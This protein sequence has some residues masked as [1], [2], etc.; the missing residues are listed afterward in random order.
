MSSVQIIDKKKR[1]PIKSADGKEVLGEIAFNPYDRRAFEKFIDMYNILMNGEK[2]ARKIE[3]DP[4]DFEEEWET[5]EELEK[6]STSLNQINQVLKISSRAWIE[7]CAGLDD[8]FGKGVC[9]IFTQGDH[10]EELLVPLFNKVIPEFQKAREPK[11]EKY[12]AKK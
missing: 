12:R 9:E 11:T 10:D 4:I 8:I 2:E 5:F 7:V 3:I 6:A 1:F